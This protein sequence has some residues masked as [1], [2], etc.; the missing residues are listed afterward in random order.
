MP[1][2]NRGERETS[3]AATRDYLGLC[4]FDDAPR[5]VVSSEYPGEMRGSLLVRLH[6]CGSDQ[7]YTKPAA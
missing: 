6:A 5:S 1:Y 2:T 4:N 7:A 3:A